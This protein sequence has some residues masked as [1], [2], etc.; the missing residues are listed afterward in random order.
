MA[1]GSGEWR[2]LAAGAAS[3]VLMP[4]L[5]FGAHAPLWAAGV[6]AALAFGGVFFVTAPRRPLDDVDVGK[7]GQG[8]IAVVRAAIE[9]AAPALDR[10]RAAAA[11]IKDAAAKARV[12]SIAATGAQIIADLEKAPENLSSVQR[13]LTYYL[14][15]SAD[16]AEGYQD[17]EA[18]GL[19]ADRRQAI[20][21]LLIKLQGAFAHF[22][23]QQADQDL[24][25]LDVDIRLIGQALDEDIGQPVPDLGGRRPVR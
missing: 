6:G 18:R 25:T 19:G 14:P 5:A 9:G 8:R 24:R 23:D 20:A 21:D 17:L 22:R 1:G 3:A 2:Y 7:I 4:V 13:L 16:L 10:L 15:Q 12:T 11:K